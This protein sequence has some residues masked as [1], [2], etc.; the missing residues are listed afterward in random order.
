M[1]PLVA[2][3][4]VPTY[5]RLNELR[6]TLDSLVNQD[7][8]YSF[9]VIVVDDG[10]EENTKSVINQYIGKLDIKYSFQEDKGF[11]AAAARNMGI[12]LANGEICVFIDNGIILHSKAI[13]EHIDIHKNSNNP[14]VVLGYVYGF[15]V[16]KKDELL[17]HDIIVNNST[18]KAIVI[19]EEKKFYDVREAYYNE[20]GDDLSTW[21][22]PFI[23]CWSGNLS[24]SRENLIAVGLFDE[25]YT[26]WGGEDIDLGI[27]LFKN[28]VKY[29]LSR[30][31]SSIH[32][33]HIKAHN[34]DND[35]KIETNEFKDE[36][37]IKS[38]NSATSVD[39]NSLLTIFGVKRERENLK[40][41]KEYMAKKHS[42]K[43]IEYWMEHWDPVEL[44]KALMGI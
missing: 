17:L 44:N 27:S 19:L 37:R 36:V 25:N 7:C 3:I 10:S 20:L 29:V 13:Q 30:K 32:Y 35:R 34:W 23:I 9:E 14:C 22:A 43:E 12:K 41:K 26:T 33:P 11:R 31:A 1:N 39:V 24:V 38:I 2:T 8:K 16:E 21:P 4:I 5:N 18:D 40:K 6:M 42:I 28:N 15:D